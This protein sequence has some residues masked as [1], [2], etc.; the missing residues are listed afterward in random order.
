MTY[1]VVIATPVDGDSVIGPVCANGYAVALAQILR[2]N[3][4]A[5]YIS[6]TVTYS[7]DV[8][9]ARNRLAA[10]VLRE[11]PDA[12]HVLWWDADVVP[13]DPSVLGRMLRLDLEIVGAPYLRKR[14]P[15][16]YAHKIFPGRGVPTEEDKARGWMEVYALGL[17]F[18]L[19]T[20]RLLRRLSENCQRYIDKTT[21][22]DRQEVRGL[23]D[24]LYMEDQEGDWVQESE[25]GSFCA[26]ARGPWP[27]ALYLG[28]GNAM[29]HVGHFAYTPKLR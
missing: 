1:K 6:P 11:M 24:L 3:R 23:F 18:T 2:D 9:R 20:T 21:N 12:T 15:D 7:A 26:R 17:G 14:V 27:I 16:A 19:T 22:G 13:L 8:V 4:D 28:E 25:D 29:A 10:M 5:G